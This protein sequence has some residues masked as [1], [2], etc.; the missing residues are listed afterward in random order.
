MTHASASSGLPRRA[1]LAAA[2]LGVVAPAVSRAQ[3]PPETHGVADALRKL[4]GLIEDTMKRTGVPGM[5]VAV[6]SNDAVVYMQG[7]GVREAGKP[8]PVDADTVF[9]LAS[10]S[11]PIASTVMASLAD[12]KVIRWDDPIVRHDPGFALHDAWVTSEVTLR[13]MFCHRSGLADHAGDTLEDIGFDRAEVLHRLR[14]MRPGSSFRS[15]YA[16]TNFGLTAAAVA[17]A[18]STGKSWEDL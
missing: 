1:A 9:Q 14:Y 10:V 5:A 4:D 7:F 18:K 17:A 6:V 3:A 8:E 15:H 12:D 13:D 11:K 16:Y 2:A